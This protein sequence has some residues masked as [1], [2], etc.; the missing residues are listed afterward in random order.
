MAKLRIVSR[1]LVDGDLATVVA[2]SAVLPASNLY[3]PDRTTIWRAAGTSATLTVSVVSGSLWVDTV[4]LMTSNLTSSATWRIQRYD[5]ATLLADSGSQLACQP[6]PLGALRWGRQPLGVNGFAFGLAAQSVYWAPSAARVTQVV[7]TI[8]DPTNTAGYIEGSRLVVGERWTPSNNFN[9][10]AV[11]TPDSLTQQR[12]YESGA[13]RSIKGARFRRLSLSLANMTPDDRAV[14][15]QLQQLVGTDR[16]FLI[17]AYP[18]SGA[19]VFKEADYT[20]LGKFPRASGITSSTFG[21]FAAPIE[22]EEV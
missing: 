21:R 19:D 12:R 6:V 18:E 22:V 11:L 20:M 7:I 3:D 4:A 1:N 5:G 2:S 15:S 14:F 10:G 17:C 8:D 9:W 16:D 13:L